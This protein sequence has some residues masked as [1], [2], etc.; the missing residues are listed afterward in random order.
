[1]EWL[2]KFAEG[3]IKIV[4]GFHTTGHFYAQRVKESKKLCKEFQKE[5][6]FAE[7]HSF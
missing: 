5:C 4:V 3:W 2:V 6:F 7:K 1:V